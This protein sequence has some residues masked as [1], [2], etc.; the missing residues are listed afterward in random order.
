MRGGKEK[1]PIAFSSVHCLEQLYMYFYLYIS[2]YTC[3][4]LPPFES[5]ICPV[6]EL[7]VT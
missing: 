1:R 7:V 2:V 4:L 3:V 5:N 6:Q